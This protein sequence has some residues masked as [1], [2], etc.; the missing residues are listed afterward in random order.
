MIKVSFVKWQISP[1]DIQWDGEDPG[2]SR[3]GGYGGSGHGMSNRSSAGRGRV[4]AKGQSKKDFLPPQNGT[5][6]K[7]AMEEIHILHTDTLIK[8]VCAICSPEVSNQG[9]I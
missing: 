4:L 8:E 7:K 3:R 6:G 2:I 1:E 5:I 9:C